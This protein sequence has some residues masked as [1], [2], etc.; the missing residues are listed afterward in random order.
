MLKLVLVATVFHEL[1]H[2]VAHI[3][4]GSLGNRGIRRACSEDRDGTNF[5]DWGTHLEEDL[6]GGTV[7]V[8]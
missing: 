1:T 5:R 2:Y 7:G 6:I 4:F 8:L 3:L